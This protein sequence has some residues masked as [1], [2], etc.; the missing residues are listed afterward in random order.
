MF[1]V[2]SVLFRVFLR[3]LSCLFVFM[4]FQGVY[5]LLLM[6]FAGFCWFLL[7]HSVCS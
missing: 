6:C 3:V 7:V 5:S 4:M 2:V 1:T